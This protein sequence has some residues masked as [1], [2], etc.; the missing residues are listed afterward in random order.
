MK[1]FS[2]DDYGA[3]LAAFVDTQGL[4]D[5]RALKASRSKLDAF[6][7]ALGTLAPAVYSN[8]SQ[9]DQIAFWINAYNGLTLEAIVDHYPIQASLLKSA[10]F[11]R[12]SIRQIPG[13]WTELRFEVV[14]KEMTLDHI[15]HQILRK[16]FNAP[17]IHMALVCAGKGCP[18]L[19]SEPYIGERLDE[20]FSDQTKKLLAQPDKFRIDRSKGRVY[21]SPIFDWFG[22]DFVKTYGGEGKLKAGRS[23]EEKAILNFIAEHLEASDRDYL[24]TAG[25]TVVYLDYDWSL[26]EQATPREIS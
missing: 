15:E 12:N 25:Y 19:R 3:V 8:W 4:V 2:Y 23:S 24:A 17:H 5:Y 13:V 18:P 26:N 9:K 14:G 22:S 11:P 7:A 6:A 1:P 16:R 21:L 10:I 20:Q